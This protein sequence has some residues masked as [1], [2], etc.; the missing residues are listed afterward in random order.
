MLEIIIRRNHAETDGSSWSFG[1]ILAMMMLIGP[2]ID[3][4]SSFTSSKLDIGNVDIISPIE[5]GTLLLGEVII[6]CSG[7]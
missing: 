5:A 1:Q 6:P 4:I 7:A 2:L 3:L